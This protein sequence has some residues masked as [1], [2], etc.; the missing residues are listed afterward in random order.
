MP[1]RTGF[2]IALLA[3]P[4]ADALGEPP[5]AAQRHPADGPDSGLPVSTAPGPFYDDDAQHPLNRLHQLLFVADVTP[6]EING[7]LPREREAGTDAAKPWYFRRRV[8][9]P[10]DRRTFGG[11]VRVSPVLEWPAERTAPLVA[12]VEE[13]LPTIENGIIAGR[14]PLE[15]LL[16]QWDALGV[17]WRLEQRDDSSPEALDALARLIRA[18]GQPRA[19]FETLPSGWKTAQ[20]EFAGKPPGPMTEPYFSPDALIDGQDEWVELS[21][22]STKLFAAPQSLRAARVFLKLP[23]PDLKEWVSQVS[24][25]SSARDDRRPAERVETAMVLSMIG[26][27]PELEPV[28]TSVIDEIRFRVVFAAEEQIDMDSTTSRDGST[29]WLYTLNR[30]A[31][32]AAHEPRF[33]F[34]SGNDQ[35]IFPEYGTAKHATYAA[36]C[37]L[38]HRLTNS[39]NQAPAGVRSLSSFAH[40]EVSS[41]PAHR[42]RL[43]EAQMAV[44]TARLKERLAAGPRQMPA[45][46]WDFRSL[47][48]K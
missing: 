33:R 28:A 46:E 11:D 38:C 6:V 16:V 26:L 45:A 36:Q 37:T 25:G 34:V 8:G 35:A 29:L 24:A 42:L 43:A 18:L 47:P 27:T 17:W 41:D 1:I 4:A 39:G 10:E 3:G 2:L 20:A 23:G 21:R 22:K 15:S 12:T 7:D 5:T 30:A 32:R 44:V 13:L 31:T 19:T 14:S 9:T 40:P 48:S